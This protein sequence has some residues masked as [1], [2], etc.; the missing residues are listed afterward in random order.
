MP[1][2]PGVIAS[3]SN[4]VGTA[5]AV[6]ANLVVM[7]AFKKWECRLERRRYTEAFFEV[8]AI[9]RVTPGGGSKWRDLAT[10]PVAGASVSIQTAPEGVNLVIAV[11]AAAMVAI[12]AMGSDLSRGKIV[13]DCR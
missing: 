11:T 10:H 5:S 1:L 3:A 7:T 12:V 2:I 9:L 6:F 13:I 8:K 4:G